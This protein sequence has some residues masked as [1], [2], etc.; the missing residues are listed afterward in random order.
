MVHCLQRLED[1]RSEAAH[2][3]PFG[4]YKAVRG[5]EK[6]WDLLSNVLFLLGFEL[7]FFVLRLSAN[8]VL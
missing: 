1:K 6:C 7:E 5:D 8:V 2:A 3:A 4:Y